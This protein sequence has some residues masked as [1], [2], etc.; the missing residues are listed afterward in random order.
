MASARFLTP[1]ERLLEME[2]MSD[3]I[4]RLL[5]E[6]ARPEHEQEE[7]MSSVNWVPA[8]D[9]VE[10]DIEY[11][12]RAELPGVDKQN[13]KISVEEG[14]LTIAGHREQEREEK[15]KRFHRIER[16]YGR[17]ARKFTVPDIVDATKVSADFKNGVLTITMPKSEK[18][19]PKAIEVTVA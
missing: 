1:M 19:R 16:A 11:Q 8:M 3:R 12:I 5:S 4:N 17:F 15:G 10:T 6:R 9:V 7:S 2:N 13:V 14:V 18:A